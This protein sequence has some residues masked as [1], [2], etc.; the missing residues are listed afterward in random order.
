VI[1]LSAGAAVR[2]SL[3]LDAVGCSVSPDGTLTKTAIQG[4]GNC[5]AYSEQRLRGDGYVEIIASEIATN[6]VFGL[7]PGHFVEPVVWTVLVGVVADGSTLIKT[8]SSAW[9]NGGAVST[10]QFASGDC[11]VEITASEMTTARMFGLSNGNTDQNFPDIDF[12]LYPYLDDQLLVYE[13]GTYRGFFG[14]YATGDKLRVGVEGGAVTYRKNGAL[15]YTSLVPP[16]YPLLVDTALYSEGATLAQ[17]VLASGNSSGNTV[18]TYTN[19]DYGF[20]PR[21]AGVLMIYEGGTSRGTFGTYA[22]GDRLRVAVEGGLVTYRKNDE[23]LYT[24]GVAPTHPLLA[25]ASLYNSGSQLGPLNIFGL[26]IG[27]EPGGAPTRTVLVGSQL[28]STVAQVWDW[29]Q[30][31]VLPISNLRGVDVLRG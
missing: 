28:R 29:D 10:Q 11:Y 9:N 2:S 16:V 19:I 18:V 6:R 12:G 4:W 14:T 17:A 7:G 31:F 24:S 26:W 21:P 20:N 15:L 1:A 30:S 13:G 5:G 25:Q 8:A 27:D 23:L 22:S 3:W